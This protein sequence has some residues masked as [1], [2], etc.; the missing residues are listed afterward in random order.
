MYYIVFTILDAAFCDVV[1]GYVIPEKGF[2]AALSEA[3]YL[4]C[5]VWHKG[6]TVY[7]ALGGLV[8][9]IAP[10]IDSPLNDSHNYL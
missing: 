1:K 6:I 3:E 7:D 10:N 9:E 8:Y 4:D 2:S 5:D